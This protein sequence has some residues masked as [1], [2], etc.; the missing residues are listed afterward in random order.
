M[1]EG[2]FRMQRKKAPKRRVGRNSEPGKDDDK[3]E[4]S[5]TPAGERDREQLNEAD[6]RHDQNPADEGEIDVET[7]CDQHVA[8]DREPYVAAAQ[9][10]KLD[11]GV[12]LTL[13]VVTRTSPN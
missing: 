11:A 8:E 3:S 2:D 7:V 6:R 9:L 5:H 1:A 4:L 13:A 12:G 10:N